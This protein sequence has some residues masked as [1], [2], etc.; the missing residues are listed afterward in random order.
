MKSNDL[1]SGYIVE[2]RNGDRYVIIETPHGKIMSCGEAWNTLV[3][4][5]DDLEH[6]YIPNLSIVKV[7]SIDC[8]NSGYAYY[9]SNL[10][11]KDNHSLILL[12]DADLYT[13]DEAIKISRPFKHNSFSTYGT[14]SENII[15]LTSK[16]FNILEELEKKVWQVKEEGI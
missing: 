4:Y 3:N 15:L 13:F 7:F 14:P 6:K 11:N 8:I 16:G 5:N 10:Q 9:P 1:K 2:L 12:W